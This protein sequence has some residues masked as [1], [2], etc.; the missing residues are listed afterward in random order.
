MALKEWAEI[1][2]GFIST[3]ALV[4]AGLWTYILFVQKRQ[5]YQ[6]TSVEHRITHRPLGGGKVLLV[7]EVL[8]TNTGDVLV[9]LESGETTVKQLVPIGPQFSQRIAEQAR[10]TR[11]Q[12]TGWNLIAYEPDDPG[13]RG[14]EI[15]PGNSD[16]SVYNFIV[17]DDVRTVQVHSYIEN[18][19][20]R[21][22][23]IDWRRFR[24]TRRSRMGWHRT[25]TYDIQAVEPSIAALDGEDQQF[26]I[27]ARRNHHDVSRS[28]T[29]A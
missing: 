4:V 22:L 5:K 24:I 29:P 2:Q 18:I 19:Q 7:V 20:K 23:R 17:D 8:V 25:T 26:V 15:E 16:Q 13:R 21:R 27:I 10:P 9:A 28:G 12:A 14:V 1:I 11:H 6:R 3:I